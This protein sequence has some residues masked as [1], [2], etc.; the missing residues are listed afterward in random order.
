MN[1]LQIL[2]PSILLIL[3]GIIT[4][5]LKTRVEELKAIE[6]KLR[7]DRRKIYLQIL[8]PYIRLFTDTSEKG[9][10]NVIKKVTSYEYKKT[11]FELNLFGSDNVVKAYNILLIH[12]LEYEKTG[13]LKPEVMWPLWGKFLIEVRKSRR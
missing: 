12:M 2:G 9:K 1:W 4:W 10:L 11:A 8:D 6:E 5:F 7:E 3:G 13:V